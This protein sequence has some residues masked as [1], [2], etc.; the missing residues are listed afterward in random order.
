MAVKMSS[1]TLSSFKLRAF[2]GL[3]PPHKKRWYNL[4]MDGACFVGLYLHFDLYLAT[5]HIHCCLENK[6]RLQH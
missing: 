4:V 5:F 2:L 3:Q 6:F 1:E